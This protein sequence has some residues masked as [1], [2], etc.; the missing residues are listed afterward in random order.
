MKPD[1]IWAAVLSAALSAVYLVIKA[2]I[3]QE[4]PTNDKF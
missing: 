3:D 2:I 1:R 4:D